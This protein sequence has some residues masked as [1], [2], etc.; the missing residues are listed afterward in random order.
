[1]LSERLLFIAITFFYEI[2]TKVF[3]KTIAYINIYGELYIMLNG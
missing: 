3:T 1:M 2:F